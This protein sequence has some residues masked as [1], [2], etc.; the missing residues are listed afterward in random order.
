MN[1]RRSIIESSRR[2][3]EV[4]PYHASN[5]AFARTGEVLIL[6]GYCQRAAAMGYEVLRRVVADLG[7]SARGSDLLRRPV[8]GL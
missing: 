3:L 7:R 6:A 4:R 5:E 8:P 1:V 2:R